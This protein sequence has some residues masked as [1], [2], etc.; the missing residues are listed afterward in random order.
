MLAPTD[1]A[2]V[3]VIA[4]ERGT[5]MTTESQ[6]P[7]RKL[8][9][10]TTLAL[11][12]VAMASPVGVVVGTVPLMIGLGDGIGTPGAFV[13]IGVVLLLFAF[14]FAAMARAIPSAGGFFGFI[15][16]GLGQR[17]G[18]SAG[19][20][21]A[22]AY[23]I[24][25][26]YVASLLAYFAN[27]FVR[28][29]AGANIDWAVWALGAVLVVAVLIFIGV[30]ESALITAG[31]LMIEFLIL[32]TLAVA[33][34][35][36]RGP[37]G[38]PL[39]SFSP[40]HV[41]SGA[42]G[43][44]LALAFLSFIGFEVTAVFTNHVRDPEKSIGRATMVGITI[45]IVVFSLGSWVTI[46]GLGSA[47]ALAISQGPDSG[48]LIPRVAEANVGEWMGVLFNVILM[49]SLFA[50][51]IAVS[52]TTAQY[53]QTMARDVAPRARLARLHP[54]HGS[55]ASAGIALAG[56][57]CAVI[58]VCRIAGLDPYV[59]VSALLG[60]LGAVAVFGLEIA[61]AV[62]IFIYFRRTRDRRVWTTVLSPALASVALTVFLVLVLTNYADLTGFSS[63]II[64]WSPML[65]VV[66]AAFGW[67]VGGTQDSSPEAGQP[68]DLRADAV[69]V[70][71][72]EETLDAR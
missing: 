57:V 4:V 7:P 60:V 22:S 33:V 66:V 46:A 6:A 62:A 32:T 65:F 2:T 63:P 40:S 19:F 52:S 58:I 26:V 30:K 59:Q 48:Q 45:L 42:P 20:V 31:L 70:H 47:S 44:A 13:L 51:L 14:G 54:T 67:L 1:C 29:H 71:D 50:T 23:A 69:A 25:T 68:E 64:T 72:L 56:L 12:V 27:A 9:G 24:I 35:V 36:R 11:M 34:L 5:N 37:S 55:P 3:P 21:A 39:E 18:V 15:R 16:A 38:F 61:C 17:T 43:F 53:V 41:F 49:T 10:P 8:M 28:A